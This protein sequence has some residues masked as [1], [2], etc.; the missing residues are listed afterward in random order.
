MI[1]L[2]AWRWTPLTGLGLALA[3]IGSTALAWSGLAALEEARD[4]RATIA[5]TAGAGASPALPLLPAALSYPQED[6]RAAEAAMLA[7][8]RKA[9]AERRLLVEAIVLVPADTAM[10]AEL[11][12]DLT[13]SGA[14][15]DILHVARVLE[16]GQPTIRFVRWR[17]GRT[18]PAE[19]AIRLDARAMAVWEPR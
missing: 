19:T 9:A 6:R 15:A 18:G 14:E 1:G 2:P 10:P 12:V 4:R 17:I 13:I 3:V 16:A 11:L 7:T 5:A 8:V